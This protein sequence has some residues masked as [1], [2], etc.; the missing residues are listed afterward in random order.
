MST[1]TTTQA[2]TIQMPGATCLQT[3]TGLVC[4]NGWTPYHEPVSHAGEYVTFGALGVVVLGI[5][6]ISHVL[7]RRSLRAT[8]EQ[9]AKAAA[10][11]PPEAVA[12]AYAAAR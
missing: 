1:T 9:T 4:H 2:A 8:Q 6:A 10:T 12:R 3:S 5:W 7:G 11:L